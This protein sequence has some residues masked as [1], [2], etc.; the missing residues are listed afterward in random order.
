MG[1]QWS[2]LYKRSEALPPFRMW[3]AQY[4][5]HMRMDA[6]T[7]ADRPWMKPMRMT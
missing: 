7:P 2:V 4:H 1:S 5:K 3:E 6:V